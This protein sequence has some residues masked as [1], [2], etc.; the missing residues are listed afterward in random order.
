[1]IGIRWI[2]FDH[3]PDR[4][5]GLIDLSYNV[6]SSWHPEAQLLFKNLNRQGWKESIH[7][8]VHMLQL[9]TPE[10]LDEAT[11]NT[12]YTNQYDAVIAKFQR[13]M[14]AKNQWF[15]EY[16]PEFRDK[17]IAYFSAEY[18][19][20]H[21]L[22]FYAGGLGFLAGDHLKEC[23]DL[24]VPVVAI[25]FMY[26][27]GY[28][29]QRVR[30]DGWQ[31]DV[32]EK[33]ERE[34]API[35]RV[36]DKDGEQMVLQVPFIVPEI[37]FA[38][39]R[40]DVGRVILY[41]IDTEIDQN[42]AHLRNISSRLYSSANEMRLLQE[43]VLGIGGTYALMALG[44]QYSAIHLNEGHAAFALIER[45][46]QKVES[47][48]APEEAWDQVKE[49]SLFTTHTPVPAGHD[50][51][52]NWMI[53]KYFSQ[54]Y[55]ALKMKRED[56]LAAGRHEEDP[57]D[58]F[59]MAA[60]SIRC[61]KF[62]NGVS[63]KHGEVA[64]KMWHFL[65]P[66]EKLDDIPI[67]SVTN[68]VHVPTWIN[69]RLTLLI[70]RYLAPIC[71]DWFDHHDKDYVWAMIDSIPDQKLWELHYGLK[72]KLI[73][74][75]H[76]FKR[77]DWMK[78]QAD[79]ANVVAGG[80]LID[81][82]ALT[83]GF[84]RRFST[85]KRADLIF[86]DLDRIK[87]ILNNS[88]T[89]VQIIFAGKAHPAD[90]EGKRILQRIYQ[91]A[92]QPEFGGRIAFVEDYGEQIA[93]YLVQGVDIWLNNPV[94]PLEASGTSGMKAAVNGVLNLSIADGWWIEGYNGKNGWIIDPES[95]GNDRD[96]DDANAIYDLLENEVVPLFY[97]FGLDGIPHG[98][99][100]MMKE[101]IKSN[102]PLFSARRMVKEYVHNYYV[103]AISCAQCQ[104]DIEK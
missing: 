47:G 89:P 10:L 20:Q 64:R 28:L 62:C 21:S 33:L 60:F 72:I 85:Y 2:D 40:V 101:S 5:S 16:Y 14:L 66:E 6:W 36:L 76:Q 27:D 9:I 51:F 38:L 42:P 54:Y 4:L 39:W 97:D 90:D 7:N 37:H 94:P 80:S 92:Q 58:T 63:K 23:S 29:H 91:Y 59:N 95:K 43:I 84:A 93:K 70:N 103:P 57:P 30:S 67:G 83:L 100:K 18:G 65:W 77:K 73:N 74:R 81:P 88:W 99:V 104:M 50:K 55:S 3:I 11:A 56:F 34:N 52:P 1:M 71:P 35:K 17:K 69:P 87:K 31:E 26:A 61:S 75:I 44:I 8:P 79:C 32:E 22:P 45:F 82:N 41:L 49:T 13:Y 12:E 24:G 102:A 86:K 78:Y 19:L 48:L 53:D 68:G 15:S 46:R 25:G 98:W 96:W